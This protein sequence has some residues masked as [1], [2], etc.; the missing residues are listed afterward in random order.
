MDSKL[1][2]EEHIDLGR[3][4][5]VIRRHWIPATATF[6]GIVTLSLV[7]ALVS[8]DV[9]EAKSELL[10]KP[11]RRDIAGIPKSEREDQRTII[12]KDPIETEAGILG[13]RTIVEQVIKELDLKTDNGKQVTYK[14]ASQ[15]LRVQPQV[16]K[17]ILEISY[18]H[19]DADVAVSFV[20]RA[21]ELYKDGYATFNSEEDLKNADFIERQLPKLE[22]AVEDA[23]ADLRTFKNRNGISDLAGQT[24]ADILAVSEIEQQINQVSADLK[25]VNARYNQLQRQLGL[26][27][28]EASAVTSLS[29]STSIQQTLN[30]LQRVKVKL[31]QESNVLSDSAPQIISLRE[32]QAD[33]DA[34]L[35]QEI[36]TSLNPQQ[37]QLAEKF[38]I[39]RLGNLEQGEL[40]QL[41]TFTDLGLQREGL[42]ERLASLRN[43]YARYQQRT[44]LSPQLQE[45]QRQ[46]ERRLKTV[47]ADLEALESRKN[48]L[49][50][51]KD[52][53][54]DKVRIITDAALTEDPVN[55]DGKIIVAA[56][57][58]MGLL[59][60]TALAFLL[61]L[62][63]NTIKNTQEVES[64]FAYPLQ[65]V[66]PDLNLG[67][68][69]EQLQLPGAG[70]TNHPHQVVSEVSMM[71]LREA[72][73]NIQVNLK[74]LDN[75][76]EK[77][78]IAIT[79]SVPQEGK[80][81]VSANLAVARS[82]CGQRVL[83]ID[84]DMRRPTQHHIWEISNETGLSEVLSQK[85]SWSSGVQ[86]VMPNLDVLTAGSIPDN[87]IALLDSPAFADF[88]AE[89]SKNYDRIIFDTPPIIGIA[90]TKII[91]RAVDGFLF[92]VRPGVADYGSATAAKKTL[93]STGLKVLGVV[94][95]GADMSQEPYHYS[96]YYYAQQK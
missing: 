47:T 80:S 16:G 51:L 68:T 86:N 89:V 71:P 37:Q 22:D 23:E 33:L 2:I 95:N 11:E 29:Q 75:D 91:G 88:I 66:V 15:A 34:L 64:M 67:G 83:L 54:V 45:Q 77:K 36:A 59:F 92:V 62:K 58:M 94:V 39:L 35:R 28:Q 13:S 42:Q 46:L 24:E 82:Q 69:S 53:R 25:G 50:I 6:A 49:E 70:A 3:Y 60:G 90:D 30:E 78:V 19:E 12:D 40:S 55:T 10:I 17:D 73:Q 85:E 87:P 63:D 57:T 14:K 56:G 27:W 4:W 61:D 72:Y 93:D 48:Q 9:Y 18:E 7:A 41:E 31:A 20:K 43:S 26:T 5:Q 76:A 8:K 96:S 32:Q 52:Y 44:N 74:L 81:S 1:P 79:S 21:V 38:N 84:A 65:G